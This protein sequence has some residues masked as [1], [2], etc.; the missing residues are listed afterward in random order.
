VTFAEQLRP[1]AERA[2]L[3]H[4]RIRQIVQITAFICGENAERAANEARQQTLRWLHRRAGPL[5]AHAWQGETFER[6]VA[7]GL[8]AFAVS[9]SEP[10]PYWVARLDHPD[11]SV[12]GRTWSTEVTVGISPQG[13][14]FGVR[15][16]CTSVATTQR[17][18]S[19][20][21]V[22]RYRW[23]INPGYKISGSA[24]PPS[25]GCSNP[26]PT[27]HGPWNCW[28]TRRELGP[29]IWF[30]CRTER[31]MRGQR[32]SIAD[33]LPGDVWVSLTSRFCRLHSHS[34]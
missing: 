8:S 15:L 29:S 26:L 25:P 27:S 3:Y 23:R 6:E 21:P 2:R 28:R 7:P 22:S 4:S 12:P 10:A 9:L 17:S 33:R 13:A 11:A 34:T 14:Q 20:R 18:N 31:S 16:S 32:W 19:R 1:V 30:P 24:S 5:P